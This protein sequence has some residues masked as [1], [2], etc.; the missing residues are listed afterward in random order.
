MK[1]LFLVLAAVLT[2]SA[3]SFAAHADQCVPTKTVQEAKA[4]YDSSVA[5]LNIS[6]NQIYTKAVVDYNSA[7][8]TNLVVY[9]QQVASINAV[10]DAEVKAITTDLPVGWQAA[11]K[12]A[13]DKHNQDLDLAIVQYDVKNKNEYAVYNLTV[14]QAKNNFDVQARAIAEKYNKAVCAQ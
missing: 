12:A 8:A 9:N 4:E 3:Q 5:A 11:L 6:I 1:N 7:T 14:N 2:F 10:Y 13:T